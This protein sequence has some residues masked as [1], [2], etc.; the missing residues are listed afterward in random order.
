MTWKTWRDDQKGVGGRAWKVGEVGESHWPRQP[1]GGRTPS[2][3]AWGA[4][5]PVCGVT[6][7]AGSPFQT[8]QHHYIYVSIILSN[9]Y[10]MLF[11]RSCLLCFPYLDLLHCQVLLATDRKVGG[12]GKLSSLFQMSQLLS[13][14]AMPDFYLCSCLSLYSFFLPFFFFLRQGFSV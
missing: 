1:L 12:E 11:V 5:E 13:G 2:G 4:G 6:H 8:R 9:V 3:S 10:T 14:G 7:S